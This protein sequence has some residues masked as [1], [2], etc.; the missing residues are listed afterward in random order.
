MG[1]ATIGA[2]LGGLLGNWLGLQTALWVCSVAALISPIYAYF[3]PLRQL[4]EQPVNR[5]FN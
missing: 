4:K 1:A 5:E 3:T 2:L